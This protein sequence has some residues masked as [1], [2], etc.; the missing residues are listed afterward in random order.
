MKKELIIS[1][2]LDTQ[3]LDRSFKALRD[4]MASITAPIQEQQQFMQV[5]QRAAQLGL[6]RPITPEEQRRMDEQI[7][8]S[9]REMESFVKEQLKH[10][11]AINKAIQNR[12]N[13]LERLNKLYRES[14]ELGKEDLKLQER[15]SNQQKAI[16]RLETAQKARERVI[17]E[18]VE[19]I[20]RD[21]KTETGG[22]SRLGIGRRIMGT[23]TGIFS[24]LQFISKAA[25]VLNEIPTTIGRGE[26]ALASGVA[27][28]ALQS[29]LTGR[30]SSYAFYAPERLKA[31]Q[32]AVRH[33]NMARPIAIV[34]LI[35]GAGMGTVINGPV[36]GLIGGI[37][38]SG[39]IEGFL[40]NLGALGIPGLS[41]I[42]E[43]RRAEA[44]V[45]KF[46]EMEEI[47]KQKSPLRRAAEQ[48]YSANYFRDLQFQRQLG[49]S[50]I[51][52]MGPQGLIRRGAEA[53]FT[54]ED[55][56]GAS[57]SIL[58]AG[59]TTRVAR[60]S[61]ILSN[62]LA[63]NF[64]LTNASQILGIIG[65]RA[66]TGA[67][68]EQAIIKMLAEG[69]RIGLNRSEL[70]QEQRQFMQ[71]AAS[72][73]AAAGV[74]GP[75]G[76]G[77]VAEMLSGFVTQ[78]TTA[79]ISDAAMAYRRFE[80]LT[81]QQ[82]GPARQAFRVAEMAR[83]A[84][85]LRTLTT[86]VE[87]R[88]LLQDIADMPISEFTEENPVVRAAMMRTGMSF[89]QL[90]AAKRAGVAGSFD[91]TGI[92]DRG[93]G[94]RLREMVRERPGVPIAELLQTQEGGTAVALTRQLGLAYGMN[95]EQAASLLAGYLGITDT[96]GVRDIQSI[97]GRMQ[98]GPE[99][100]GRRG[101]ITRAGDAAG[102]AAITDTVQQLDEDFKNAGRAAAQ[103][104]AKMIEIIGI[105]EQS[106][107]NKD[108]EAAREA[109]KMLIQQ[110]AGPQS[111]PSG[112]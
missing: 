53:G 4:K 85:E 90:M 89:E 1:A 102:F 82:G 32:E 69:T 25:E 42:F 33:S 29:A 86:D 34:R 58:A 56:F 40:G 96:R 81:G 24:A 31:I 75:E 47:E 104:S 57:A 39:G 101:D 30:M 74:R 111:A 91:L 76:F 109:A 112:K 9:N 8:R 88:L 50:D 107:K 54:Q 28:G 23:L 84:P 51:E 18:A 65:G 10:H 49:I 73:G 37:A 78:T 7:K 68:S 16:T 103:F 72:I 105:I 71:I 41:R 79:G 110:Q 62:V 66:G 46:Q 108:I 14:I 22:P 5:R 19:R 95:T 21:K 20:E 63:R 59:G 12:K 98:G 2:K 106:V 92:L 13:E 77:R 36:G 17:E 6:G 64:D 60:E 11:D 55:I 43:A 93:A 83:Q 26:A 3:E 48:Y 35:S 61:A 15:I 44:F 38:A 87:G 94:A 70:V 52:L 67:A 100:T 45:R 99:L 97:I 80:E 27:G